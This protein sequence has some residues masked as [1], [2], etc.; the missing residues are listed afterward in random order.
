MTGEPLYTK[1]MYWMFS[2]GVLLMVLECLIYIA[3]RGY[4]ALKT[5]WRDREAEFQFP[6][7]DPISK[8]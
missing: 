6:D 1:I 7:G 8:T 5:T 3:I 4:W 2:A